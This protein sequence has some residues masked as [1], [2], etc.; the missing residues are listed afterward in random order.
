[1]LPAN[2]EILNNTD[3]GEEMR[4]AGNALFKY[5]DGQKEAPNGPAER[6]AIRDVFK[7][8]LKGLHSSGLPKH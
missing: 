7:G 1:M 2:R 5:L 6:D 3:A 8:I 4:L